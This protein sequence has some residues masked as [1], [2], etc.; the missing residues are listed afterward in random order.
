MFLRSWR[1]ISSSGMIC[2]GA[3]RGLKIGLNGDTQEP[4]Q[5]EQGK[6]RPSSQRESDDM[7]WYETVG[8]GIYEALC[9]AF[10]LDPDSSDAL[11]KFIPAYVE[12]T[13]TPQAPRNANVCYYNIESYS[14]ESTLDY[15]SHKQVLVNGQT[16]TEITKSVPCSVLV[17]FYGPNADDDAEKFW[18]LFQWDNGVNSP[19]SILR[20]KKIVPIGIPAR[21]ISLF[22]VEG[23]YQ[24][25]RS[26]VRVNLAYLDIS[27]H[28]SSEVYT[29]PE[30]VVKSQTN[31]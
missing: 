27:E 4:T 11:N 8:A 26:D 22:E 14:G 29:P 24:R 7:G 25:R 13:E 9:A 19:R 20:K 18:S 6:K 28:V 17:T 10:G 21:P 23:T 30:V 3:L 5:R 15:I 31:N 12:D 2:T 1:R 16:K